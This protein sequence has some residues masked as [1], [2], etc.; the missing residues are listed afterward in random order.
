VKWL[1]EDLMKKGVIIYLLKNKI[2]R[3]KSSLLYLENIF[4]FANDS[5]C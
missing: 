5:L 1:N 3:Q 4:T 2:G